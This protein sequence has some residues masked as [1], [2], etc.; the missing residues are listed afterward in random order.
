MLTDI[1]THRTEFEICSCT[2]SSDVIRSIS[3]FCQGKVKLVPG[4]FFVFLRA[5]VETAE[6]EMKIYH[7]SDVLI[8]SRSQPLISI[9]EDLVKDVRTYG[10]TSVLQT[11]ARKTTFRT[12]CCYFCSLTIALKRSLEGRRRVFSSWGLDAGETEHRKPND[13]RY[14]LIANGRFCAVVYAWREALRDVQAPLHS[15]P[16]YL[17]MKALLQ[18]SRL[19]SD[20]QLFRVDNIDNIDLTAAEGASSTGL[21]DQGIFR[22]QASLLELR[23][24]LY[25]TRNGNVASW[26]LNLKHV[27]N[28]A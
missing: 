23:V 6:D 22:G 13:Q 27:V 19:L 15:I 28:L 11:L 17:D 4:L 14:Q 7:P 5:A 25:V 18:P 12:R 10:W 16:A 3:C 21:G 8:L 26:V 9:P 1:N 24:K 20:K 2:Q